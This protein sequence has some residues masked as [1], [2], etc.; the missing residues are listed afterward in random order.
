MT[1]EAN[2]YNF[3]SK[4]FYKQIFEASGVDESEI[5]GV[6]SLCHL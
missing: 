3:N 1:T 2:P 5:T 6:E 4:R